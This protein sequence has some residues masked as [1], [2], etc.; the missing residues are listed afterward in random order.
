MAKKNLSATS[1]SKSKISKPQSL[2]VLIVED[3]EEDALL[4]IR[5]LKKGGYNPVYERVETVAAMKK[6]IQEKQ[7]DII[8]CDYKLRKFNTSSA[9]SLL[10]EINIDV[11]VIMVSG[12]IGEE[13]VVECMRSGARDYIMKNNLSRLCP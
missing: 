6:S 3:S 13:A 1:N 9:I 4:E 8:L 11:P 2:K 7:W 10:K 12:T 5:E